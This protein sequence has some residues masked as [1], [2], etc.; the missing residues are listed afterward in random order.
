VLDPAYLADVVDRSCDKYPTV[1][2]VSACYS[3]VFLIDALKG[4]NRIIMT[5][6]RDDRPSFG[7]SSESYY[8]YWDACLLD[9][10][11]AGKL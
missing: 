4:P 3:G 11:K 2:L 6:A 10:I 7:C 9:T 5:A 1:I 8:T